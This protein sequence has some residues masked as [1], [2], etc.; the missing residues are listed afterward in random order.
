MFA[1]EAHLAVEVT[2]AIYQD[3]VAA[4]RNPDRRA[5]KAALSKTLASLRGGG[6]PAA[7]SELIRLGRTLN[8]RAGDVLAYCDRSGTSN[9][10]DRGD[11]RPTG[12]PVPRM[13]GH[14]APHSASAT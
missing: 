11:Q 7:L 5:A 14:A 8:R 1:D 13:V 9:A 2:W 10:P 6:L 4:Y 12:T 3:I